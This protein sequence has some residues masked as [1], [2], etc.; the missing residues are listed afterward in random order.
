M[1]I[2]SLG[3]FYLYVYELLELNE[4]MIKTKYNTTL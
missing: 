3:V 2:G 1:G 4:S